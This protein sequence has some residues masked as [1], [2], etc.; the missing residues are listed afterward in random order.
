M[1]S[2]NRKMSQKGQKGSKTAILAPFLTIFQRFS[3]NVDC[4]LYFEIQ[5]TMCG[6]V[7]FQKKNWGGYFEIRGFKI[8][9]FRDLSRDAGNQGLGG[10]EPGALSF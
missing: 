9:H 5:C 2:A 4:G 8:G 7:V 3:T 6:G 10:D 1:V